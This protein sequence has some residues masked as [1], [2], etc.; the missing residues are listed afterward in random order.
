MAE[1]Q[2]TG[3]EP[4][5]R[6]KGWFELVTRGRPPFLIDEETIYKNGLKAGDIISDPK[7][8][9]IKS[10]SD[11]AWLKYKGMQILSRRM[12]SERDLRRKLS[13]ER[14]PP[15][16]T[17]EALADLKRYGFYDD[18]RYAAAFVRS[19]M[20]RGVKSRLYL[21]KKLWEKGISEAIAGEI[22]ASEL[23][24]F[25]ELSAV[26]ELAEKKYGALRGL[27]KDRARSRL[28]NFL[29][30]KGFSW[31]VIREAVDRVASD[32]SEES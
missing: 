4:V 17:D 25:D 14:K 30:G 9:K 6:K 22:L 11:L 32:E 31:D 12:L 2:I 8:K 26:M 1:L 27:P 23:A 29:R 5:K 13:A 21:K 28:I 16:T 24:E 3:I 18:A 20:A 15:A 19:Q 10:E 7:W